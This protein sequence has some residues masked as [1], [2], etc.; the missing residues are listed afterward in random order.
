MTTQKTN[1]QQWAAE[2]SSPTMVEHVVTQVYTP[3][4]YSAIRA[5]VCHLADELKAGRP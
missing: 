3:G 2:G 1:P 5:G 4:G